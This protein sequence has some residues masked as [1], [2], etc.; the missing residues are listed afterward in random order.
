[1]YGLK[2][3]GGQLYLEGK[4]SEKNLYIRNGKISRISQEQFDAK[5]VFDAARCHV[6]PG[7]IDSHVH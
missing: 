5:T 1:M 7:L 6:M 4:W 2:I 3:V